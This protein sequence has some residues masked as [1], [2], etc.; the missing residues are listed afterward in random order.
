MMTYLDVFQIAS[1]GALLLIFAARALHLLLVRKINPIAIGRGKKGLA[2][3]FELGAF[4]GLITWMAAVV[5][6]AT[7]Q[8]VAG[9]DAG[10]YWRLFDSP[11]ARALG[12]TLVVLAMLLFAL[13]F[14]SF[15]DSWRVGLDKQTPG[16]LVT[17]GVFAL[18]RNPI[19]VSMDLWFIGIALINGTLFFVIFAALAAAALHY[20]MLREERFCTELYGEPYKAYRASTARYVIW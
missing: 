17:R 7:H 12:V 18:S 5:I 10:L 15:G 9:Y 8:P 2:L 14:L 19:Y 6:H 3:V 1:I 16:P 4:A 20:Q 13:A 11:V